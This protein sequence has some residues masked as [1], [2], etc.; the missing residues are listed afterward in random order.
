[1]LKTK[2]SMPKESIL[3]FL[4]KDHSSESMSHPDQRLG[5]RFFKQV[6]SVVYPLD[7]KG[8]NIPN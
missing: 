6:T 7:V 5:P 2:T 1:M 3:K 8:H 4:K